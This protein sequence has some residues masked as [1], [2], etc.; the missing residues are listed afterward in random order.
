MYIEE[1]FSYILNKIE[2]YGR[3]KVSDLSRE[4][5]VSEVTIRKDLTLLEERE[6]LRRTF[7]G[8]VALRPHVKQ[9]SLD[10]KRVENIDLKKIIG[11]KCGAYL[12][13][14]LD[15]FLDSG[16][17]TYEI[18]DE[19]VKYNDIT[20]VTYDLAIAMKLSK[21]PH[22]RTY[23]LGGYIENTTDVALSIEGVRTLSRLH[24]D[25][26]F[27]GT[28]AFDDKRVYSTSDIKANVKR[29]MLENSK[30]RVL[31]SD[32]SKFMQE[33]LFSFYDLDSFDCIISDRQ[34]ANLNKLLDEN[35]D[36]LE[37]K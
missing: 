36:N 35:K 15:I 12:H 19:I 11:A 6:Y 20:V 33:G 21:Y 14:S 25:I 16:T 5:D 29:T 27:I 30:F 2:K 37:D 1:R 3:V 8:A 31:V 32:S 18:I 26:C 4:L 17:T 13:D 34:N 9:S 23:M 7:G 24:A 22:I 10:E 28:D